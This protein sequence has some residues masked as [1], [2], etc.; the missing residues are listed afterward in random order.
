MHIINNGIRICR[1]SYIKKKSVLAPFPHNGTMQLQT[2]SVMPG[3][4]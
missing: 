1:N 2:H 4:I 3:H